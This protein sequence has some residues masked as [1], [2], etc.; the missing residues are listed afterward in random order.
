MRTQTRVRERENE[1]PDDVSEDLKVPTLPCSNTLQKKW[2]L[3]SVTRYK[4]ERKDK[5]YSRSCREIGT[6]A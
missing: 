5:R 2:M 6:S 1:S 4:A 3:K